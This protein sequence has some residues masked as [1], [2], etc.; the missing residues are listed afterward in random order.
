MDGAFN[1]TSGITPE[2]RTPPYS[3]ITT[4]ILTGGTAGTWYVSLKDASG[5]EV[6]V[7]PDP[8][9]A[10]EANELS[11]AT[12]VGTN[13]DCN[14]NSAS[15]VVTMEAGKLGAGGL[16]YATIAS[17]SPP[18][19]VQVAAATFANTTG[20]FS[21]L[22]AGSYYVAVKDAN[23]C[24]VVSDS[25]VN[26]EVPDEIQVLIYKENASCYS[27]TILDG[28]LH[29][30]VS[31][32][33]APYTYVWEYDPNSWDMSSSVTLPETT[34]DIV[35]LKQGYYRLTLTDDNGCEKIIEN[36]WYAEILEEWVSPVMGIRMEI[37][38]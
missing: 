3:G 30:T 31:G 2:T 27:S 6:E 12:V 18:T 28:A 33:V 1:Y 19:T 36:D 20:T 14:L 21:S 16:T 26:V 5:C 10:A 23:L 37:L 38:T 13:A 9:V 17:T 7:R 15:I 32:G 11:I 4:K 25:R 24:V 35:N 8:V 22:A 34:Q 29:A